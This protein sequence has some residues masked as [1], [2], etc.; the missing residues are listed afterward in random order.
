MHHLHNHQQVVLVEFL[1]PLGQLVHINLRSPLAPFRSKG[2]NSYVLVSAL[3]LLGALFTSRTTLGLHSVLI[4]GN[5]T[6]L[7]Q[8]LKESRLGVLEGLSPCKFTG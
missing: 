7:T 3:L 4:T 1:Q 5:G 6:H 2:D 8:S